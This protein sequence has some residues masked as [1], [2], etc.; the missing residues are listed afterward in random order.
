MT[1]PTFGIRLE[2]M[3]RFMSQTGSRWLCRK[4]QTVGVTCPGSDSRSAAR[5][6]AVCNESLAR[7]AERP[8]DDQQ[9]ERE[10][11]GA[12]TDLGGREPAG[13]VVLVEPQLDEELGG[14]EPSQHAR[15]E[16]V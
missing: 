15:G 13:G 8:E 9:G 6:R 4:R 10:Q 5:R 12:H 14:E 3:S 2:R 11:R 16:V 7:A 1:A